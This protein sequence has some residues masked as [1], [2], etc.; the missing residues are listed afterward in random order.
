MT[1]R[2]KKP[3]PIQK[4]LK[5]FVYGAAGVGKTTAAIQF[6][7]AYLID[8]E[9][10]ADPYTKTI[11]K[12]R[13]VVFASNNFD[14]VSKEVKELLTT[15]HDYR[16]LIIDPVTQLYNSVQEKWTRSEE[17]T[18]ELQSPDHLVC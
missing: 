10:G 16:T 6:P 5:L 14:E 13:S 4:R 18:S 9:R 3:E 17:H 15:K 1:L 7:S 8:T 12:S 11:N 2:A